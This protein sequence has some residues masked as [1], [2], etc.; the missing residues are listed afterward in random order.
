[1]SARRLLHTG[2]EGTRW[3]LAREGAEV[4]VLRE[5]GGAPERIGL[6]RFLDGDPAAPER[7]AL[8]DLVASLAEAGSATC[9]A[10]WTSRSPPS[11]RPRSPTRR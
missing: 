8:L 9:P 5:G 3:S 2:P 4:F 1:M 10:T 7:R 6:A 11:I